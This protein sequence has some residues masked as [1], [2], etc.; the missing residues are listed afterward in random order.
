M[1]NIH[2]KET[3]G[4]KKKI[5]PLWI[6]I[7][8][9]L[10]V[11]KRDLLKMVAINLFL[12]LNL[13]IDPIVVSIAIDKFI[14]Q[15]NSG[16][17]AGLGAVYFA[18]IIVVCCVVYYFCILGFRIEAA[19]SHKFRKDLFDKIQALSVEYFDKNPVGSIISRM[20]SDTNRICE[21]LAWGLLDLF[22]AGGYIAIMS[23]VMLIANV[24]LAL[25]IL[26][27]IPLLGFVTWFLSR[28]VLVLQRAV[29]SA[30]SEMTAKLSDGIFGARTSKVLRREKLNCE[31]FGAVT[32]KMKQ[33]SI[34]S[35]VLA[36][37][38]TPA[39]MALSSIAMGL[40]LV[41][42]GGMVSRGEI[43]I[44]M[45]S[46]FF[47]YAN[48]IFDPITQVIDI[49]SNLVR[50]HA[51]GE[52]VMGLLATEPSVVDTAESVEKYGDI[53]NPRLENWEDID[54]DIEFRNVSFY[55]K[56]GEY[57]LRNFNLKV[58]RGTTVALVGRTGAGKTTIV[59]LACR[60]YEPQEG[61][62]LID[63][64]DY[65]ERTQ[66]WLHSHLGYVLQTP[67][68][69]SGTVRENIAYGKMDASDDEIVTAAKL[70]RAHDFIEKLADGYDTQVGEGGAL[71]SGGQKQLISFARAVLR[72]PAIFVL[73]EATSS[74]DTETESL[75]QEALGVVLKNRTSFVVAHRLS[76]IRNADI[77]LVIDDGG[78]AEQGNHA[79]LMAL[80]GYYYKL[81][82]NQR[83]D[84]GS[85]KLLSRAR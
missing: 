57:I 21:V 75:L 10:W 71:L 12:A 2:I 3:A 38:Y 17:L 4:D 58:P 60:F 46:L 1:E 30:N 8:K 72:S 56:E 54:G 84:E 37:A 85:Q 23:V 18:V 59:N 64:V 27:C 6:G 51:A 44:G 39:P 25:I 29:R 63:G 49:F 7:I 35:S 62:I 42:G 61:Q 47:S 79:E 77:I 52:R 41:V 68:L 76:T 80:R 43:T 69:F 11:L 36:S 24:K 78:I 81:Y 16:G 22:W 33:K 67:F 19:M 15:K 50:A 53:R 20:G 74:V 9:Y 34:A 73:D 40:V 31:E 14:T 55:Y 26:V 83:Y 66:G 13:V 48:M 28:K 5:L 45:V 65:R 32:L 82:T 70:V